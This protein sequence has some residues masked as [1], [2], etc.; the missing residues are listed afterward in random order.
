MKYQLFIDY[1]RVRKTDYYSLFIYD[2]KNI[3]IVTFYISE[4]D[5]QNLER[6]GVPKK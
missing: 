2:S 3:C 5:Y 1:H 6:A 4:E